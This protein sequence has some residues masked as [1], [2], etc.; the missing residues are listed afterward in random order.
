MN[1]DKTQKPK[2]GSYGSS[3]KEQ[4]VD[5]IINQEEESLLF[6][7]GSI[8]IM[9]SDNRQ[10]SPILNGSEYVS[11]TLINNYLYAMKHGYNFIYYHWNTPNHSE[12]DENMHSKTKYQHVCGAR[13]APWCKILSAYDAVNNSKANMIGYL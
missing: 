12:N 7:K 8:T 3:S 4:I 10:I 11:F 2:Y 13:S 6:P 9:Q 1:L 5:E